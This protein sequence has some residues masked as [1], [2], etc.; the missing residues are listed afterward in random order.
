MKKRFNKSWGIVFLLAMI[1]SLLP[2]SAFATEH[3]GIYVAGIEIT[4]DNKDDVRGPGISGQNGAIKYDPDT[5]TLTL[6]G[7]SGI[8]RADIDVDGRTYSVGIY[9]T[10]E[11][12]KL[13]LLQANN[14]MPSTSVNDSIGIWAKNLKVFGDAS[15]ATSIAEANTTAGNSIGILTEGDLY[16]F[17]ANINS[18]GG[19]ATGDSLGLYVRGKF[20]M[21]GIN[22]HASGKTRAIQ[23]GSV[24]YIEPL[25]AVK[26]SESVVGE[27]GSIDDGTHDEDLYSS[28][29]PYKTVR[30]SNVGRLDDLWVKGTRVTS[31]NQTGILGDGSV[32]F[33]YD[34][35]GSIKYKLIL[36]NATINA[37]DLAIESSRNLNIEL[38]GNNTIKVNNLSGQNLT[39]IQIRERATGELKDLVLSG[40][41]KLTIEVESVDGVESKAIISNTYTQQDT[42]TLY[43]KSGTKALD[44]ENVA[45]NIA[46]PSIIASKNADMYPPVKVTD[47]GT[48]K[49][50]NSTYKVVKIT[51]DSSL[52]TTLYEAKAMSENSDVKIELKKKDSGNLQSIIQSL[53]EDDIITVQVTVKNDKKELDRIEIYREGI[54]TPEIITEGEDFIIKEQNITEVKAVLKDKTSSGSSGSGGSTGAGGG[55]GSSNSTV[56]PP[57]QGSAKPDDKSS[58]TDKQSQ[59]TP[60]QST[61]NGNYSVLKVG[62]NSY[63]VVENGVS[64][65][66]TTDVAVRVHK[67]R[68]VLP[69]RMIAEL[70][71]VE[72][73]Y[74]ASTK[75]ATFTYNGNSATLKLGQKYMTVNGE[76]VALTSDILN[77]QGRILLPLT[78][79]QKAFAKLG[80]KSS[81]EWNQS[82]KTV[83]VSK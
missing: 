22:L 18:A 73:K 76:K 44:V 59:T 14:I 82:A 19:N 70:L 20:S 26:R 39:G 47:S 2:I 57:T 68:T 7:V 15:G 63:T 30:L 65:Q 32:K 33:V 4:S 80:L 31:G 12:L 42:A 53:R 61:K 3:Y 72:V 48:L 35:D 24:G 60:S 69:A 46:N 56:R 34:L 50:D 1:F 45:I 67:G 52:S 28:N 21:E 11:D 79:I 5:K 71:E 64:R 43:A 66:K 17:R 25:L 38:H 23:A 37:D 75:T 10:V 83:T 41:G 6:N 29:S 51:P 13:Q 49:D 54:A 77:V 9:S 62:S 74:D 58:Q 81:I 36:N 27:Y 78:D 55:G 16:I 40:N 8:N